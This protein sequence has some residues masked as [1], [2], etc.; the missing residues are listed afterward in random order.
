[1]G[2]STPL[3]LVQTTDFMH[4][5]WKKGFCT[6]G[7]VG[8]KSINYVTKYVVQPRQDL[9][10]CE[11]TFSLMSTRPAIG[12]EYLHTH[13]RYHSDDVMRSYVPMEDG[14][15]RHMPRYYLETVYILR[16]RENFRINMFLMKK[17]LGFKNF[18]TPKTCHHRDIQDAVNENLRT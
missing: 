12:S 13:Q 17:I 11:K 18:L 9:E 1:M 8:P 6:V 3:N 16:K 7:T 15:K 14:T 5:V 10:F 4:T 2:L